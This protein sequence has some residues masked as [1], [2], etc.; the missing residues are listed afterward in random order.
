MYWYLYQELWCEVNAVYDDGT[1]TRLINFIFHTDNR[2]PIR[3][4]RH[5]KRIHPLKPL[6]GFCGW[7]IVFHPAASFPLPKHCKPIASLSLFQW[8]LFRRATFFGS[9]NFNLHIKIPPFHV[10]G[11]EPLTFFSRSI[12]KKAFPHEY[13]LRTSHCSVELNP[14]KILSWLLRFWLLPDLG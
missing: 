8:Q 6:Y 5:R 2:Y 3:T 1:W 13:V 7:W 10:H 11:F 14:E 4:F 9:M 12:Y